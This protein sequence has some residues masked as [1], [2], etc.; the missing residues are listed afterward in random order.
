MKLHFGESFHLPPPINGSSPP[1][2]GELLAICLNTVITLLKR[3]VIAG[4]TALAKPGA[5]QLRIPCICI[6][7]LDRI[8]A[9]LVWFVRSPPSWPKNPVTRAIRS[10]RIPANLRV[11]HL[12]SFVITTN[13]IN[14]IFIQT[15]FLLYLYVYI[16]YTIYSTKFIPVWK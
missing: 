7:I 12:C 1:K 4:I 10:W 15:R 3:L 5:I 8:C 13:K 14:S 9:R 2:N 16:S 6:P 11:L